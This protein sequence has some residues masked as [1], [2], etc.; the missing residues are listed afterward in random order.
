MRGLSLMPGVSLVGS[1]DSGFGISHPYDCHVYLLHFQGEALLV[2]AGIGLSADVILRNIQAA[3]VPPE[4]LRTVL[5][6]HA[7]PDHSGGAAALKDRLPHLQLAASAPVAD[8]VE[9][10]DGR[11]L[12]LEAGKAAEFYPSE[13]EFVPCPVDRRL[14]DGDRLELGGVEV[15]VLETPGHSQGHLVFLMN[16]EAGRLLFSG[17][18]IFFG[19]LISLSSN[20]DCRLDQYA[21]SLAKLDGLSV[22]A[23]LPGHHSI[24]L[25]RGQRH[26]DAANRLIQDGFVPKSLV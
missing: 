2:D 24:S 9:Q 20:W 21:R 16:G 6:T 18:L 1:G 13:Y 3:G 7:H 19:G 5:L 23:L 4:R 25:S 15:R 22:D 17:D 8:A 11:G 14:A 26:I 12:N 10:A